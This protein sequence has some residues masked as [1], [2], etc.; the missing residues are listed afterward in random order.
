MTAASCSTPSSQSSHSALRHTQ[1][2]GP[3]QLYLHI[4]TGHMLCRR[5]Q[6]NSHALYQQLLC[7]LLSRNRHSRS[8]GCTSCLWYCNHK[9]H[10]LHCCPYLTQPQP[11]RAALCVL[12]ASAA[13]PVPCPWHCKHKPPPL[14]STPPALLPK[15]GPSTA[16]Q[17]CSSFTPPLLMQDT[18]H[19]RA[20]SGA[21]SKGLTGTSPSAQ[22]PLP[23]CDSGPGPPGT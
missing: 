9:P 16:R 15:Y 3:T 10:P 22:G 7:Q 13:T 2:S 20:Y 5:E 6:A 21:V 1:G 23:R 17:L 11:S 18:V 4:Q 19:T 14:A 12:S 8:A